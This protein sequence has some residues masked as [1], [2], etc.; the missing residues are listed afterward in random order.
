LELDVTV[1]Q[2]E[3]ILAAYRT[4]KSKSIYATTEH[5]R[6]GF[7]SVTTPGQIFLFLSGKRADE[8]MSR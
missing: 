5:L 8:K 3:F 6:I 1:P 7:D 2:V 4:G